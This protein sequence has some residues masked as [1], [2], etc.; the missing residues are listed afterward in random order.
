M[1][2]YSSPRSVVAHIKITRDYNNQEQFNQ[3]DTFEAFSYNK[4]LDIMTPIEN[5]SNYM[6]GAFIES[7]FLNEFYMFALK[8]NPTKANRLYI[9]AEEGKNTYTIDFISEWR[10]K[11]KKITVRNIKKT[12][13]GIKMRNIPAIVK[14][15]LARG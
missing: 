8:E 4:K 11:Q 15:T 5:C 6:G 3:M 7:S 10:D 14:N 1:S 2:N 9:F 13:E 12:I